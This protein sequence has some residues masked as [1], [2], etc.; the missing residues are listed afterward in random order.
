MN[1]FPERLKS[2]IDEYLEANDTTEHALAA[3]LK[4]GLSRLRH[5]Y[6]RGS[7]PDHE[8]LVAI[9][10]KLGR[11]LNWLMGREGATS[12]WPKERSIDAIASELAKIANKIKD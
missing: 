10:D 5:Y 2:S 8:T 3:D 4:I 12:E 1:P 9:A 11:D 7:R 6:I